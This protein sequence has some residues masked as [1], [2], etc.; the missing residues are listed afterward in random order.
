MGHMEVRG[1]FSFCKGLSSRKKNLF[2]SAFFT[3]LSNSN[4]SYYDRDK[5]ERVLMRE[6]S[7][8]FRR[9]SFFGTIEKGDVNVSNELFQSVGFFFKFPF[10]TLSFDGSSLFLRST[11]FRKNR[12]EQKRITE[13]WTKITNW[14]TSFF[15]MFGDCFEFAFIDHESFFE[16]LGGDF[17]GKSVEDN[18]ISLV[19]N[20][21]WLFFIRDSNVKRFNINFSRLR[22][23]KRILIKNGVIFVISETPFGLMEDPKNN[24]GDLNNFLKKFKGKVTGRG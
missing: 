16:G 19:S 5:E 9:N 6:N 14:F 18:I 2:L 11:V 24:Y 4:F 13:S 3:F 22:V 8:G 23:F 10:M 17:Q 15:S 7:A 20:T 21:P 1:Y 12:N